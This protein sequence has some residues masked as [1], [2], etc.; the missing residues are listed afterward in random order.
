M[1][2]KRGLVCLYPVFSQTT[3]LNS[4]ISMIQSL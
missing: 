2:F 4:S 3:A 1:G